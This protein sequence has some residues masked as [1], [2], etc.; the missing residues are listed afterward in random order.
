[1]RPRR[2]EREITGLSIA[3]DGFD[4]YSVTFKDCEII[5]REGDLIMDDCHFLNCRLTLSGKAEAVARIVALFS[6][7]KPIKFTTKDK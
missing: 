6:Q 1:M 4:W 2:F 7:G 5:L 3:V